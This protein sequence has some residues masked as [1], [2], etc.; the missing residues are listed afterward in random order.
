MSFAMYVSNI[1]Y[2]LSYRSRDCLYSASFQIHLV[3][4]LYSTLFNYFN[5]MFCYSYF[6]YFTFKNILLACT[7][8]TQLNGAFNIE[9]MKHCSYSYSYFLINLHMMSSGNLYISYMSYAMY[10]YYITYS[11]SYR[12]TDCLFTASYQINLVLSLYSTL[13][14]YFN[15]IF[16][17]SYFDYLNFKNM[18]FACTILT[19]LNGV[20]II[21]FMK[22]CCYSYRAH[23]LTSVLALLIYDNLF[24]TNLKY[25]TVLSIVNNYEIKNGFR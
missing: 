18:L 13:F 10:L 4:S 24:T 9:L 22:H 15:C 21:E 14:Y 25:F 3:L 23:L 17:C 20:Y 2:S 1:T 12:S 16:C 8:L 11:L 6:D 19:Q 5:C 7:I